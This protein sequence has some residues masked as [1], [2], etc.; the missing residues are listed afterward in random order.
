VAI[1]V[2]KNWIKCDYTPP[3]SV[4][5]GGV[6]VLGDFEVG[7]GSYLIDRN[8]W[9]IYINN[10]TEWICIGNPHI[11]ESAVEFIE[12]GIAILENKKLTSIWLKPE[13]I[14]SKN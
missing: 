7:V 4:E 1:A 8:S 9:P 11:K 3:P 10:Q 14:D 6:L 13:F 12:N 2:I 5:G